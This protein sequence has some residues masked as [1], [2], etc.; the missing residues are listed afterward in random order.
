[1]AGMTSRRQLFGA[2]LAAAT[3]AQIPAGANGLPRRIL[4]RTG[5]AVSIL[6]LGGAHL[7]RAGLKDKAEAHRMLHYAIDQGVNFLDNAWD[8]LDGNAEL[9]M[10]EGL[11]D[12]WREKVFLM[13]KNCGRDY[14]S[15]RKCLEDSLKRLR[16]DR[17]DLWQFHEINYDS[18]PEMVME[19]GAMKFAQEAVKAGKVRYL[20][21]TGHKDPRIHLRML[22]K[23]A[24]ASAQ[25]PINVMDA[26]Y[27]SFQ[28]EVL[29]AC[30]KQQTGVIGM[31]C[32]GGGPVEGR[33]PAKTKVTAEQ[34]VRFSLSLP[35]TTLCRGYTTM[36]QLEQD[37]KIAR[38]FRPLGRAE[39][40]EI[41]K[42]AE[43][44]AGDG[45]HELFKSTQF[46]DGAVH[47]KQHGFT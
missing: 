35:I 47:R 46:Y 33:I 6:C 45:R 32:L 14:E 8:Y 19:Q 4:G 15:S 30:V 16:T 22:A 17:I 44:E 28:R 37:L 2:S 1:M 25:M 40:D 43:P 3:P 10:G 12:G 5:Q 21:F 24:W 27:R 42:L 23:H 9:I 26:F 34:C 31:K 38:D 39:R 18:D 13:T 36:A 11:T 41:L 20:G 7:G 29:P